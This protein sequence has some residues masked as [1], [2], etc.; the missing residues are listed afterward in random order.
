MSKECKYWKFR[1]EKFQR[2]R[3]DLLPQ[4]CKSCSETVDKQEVKQ[5]RCEIKDLQSAL[6]NMTNNIVKDNLV[7]LKALVGCLASEKQGC[8]HSAKFAF[9]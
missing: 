3:P 4:I 7:K 8:C 2:G 9:R 1:H 6:N 5:L